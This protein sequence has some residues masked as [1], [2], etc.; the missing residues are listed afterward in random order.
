MSII[1]F[2]NTRQMEGI[3][4][5][6][7]QVKELIESK[8]NLSRTVDREKRASLTTNKV[9]RICFIVGLSLTTERK[10]EDYKD[11]QLSTTSARI[12]PSFFTMHDL[13]TLYSA[14]LKLRYAS[15]NIDWSQNAVLSRII[16]AEML[17]GR[18]Y[19]LADNNLDSIL[20]AVNNKV[21]MVKDIP[22]LNLII[23]NYGDV[24]MEATLD[25]NSR[26]IT[27]SQI[28]IAGATGSGKTNLLAVLMQQFRALSS[29]S[30]YPV[31]FLLFD[32]K[33]EFS[34]IQ[35]NH[36]LTHFDVDRSCILDPIE[37]PLP[38]TP[39]KDFTDRPINEIN[40]YSSEMAS[41]LC[42][43]D[44]VSASA[45]MNNRLSEAIVEAYKKTEGA[46]ITFNMMLEEY[47][48]KMTDAGKDDS[49]SSVLKQLVR[50]NIF[51]EKD[52]ADLVGDCYIIKMDGYPKDGPIAKAIVYFIIS[53]LNNIYEQ[54]E[55]QATNDDVV[56]IRH[57]SIIDEAHYMLDFDNRPLRN[58]IAVGRNKGLSI[59][60]ATQNMSSFKSKGFD[61]Y[62]N[63]QYP[64]IMKQQTIDDKVIKDLYGV[65]GQELQ[66]VRT[67]I[68][69]LQKGE[70]II[71]DQMAFALGMGKK[72]KK[73]NVTHLI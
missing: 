36:W 68:A 69:G 56:Q 4:N 58:L 25:I 60:L 32:Y 71:K 9:M 17:R 65:S 52:K 54:L 7:S 12:V 48:A 67:A 72:Y 62:A 44:R 57:F 50:A 18:N 43:I 59:I 70:L 10:E 38:F 30:Q 29:E 6:I 55:K 35:N 23:G 53:K 40:L 27:N 13:S 8:I 39:F 51:E 42:S 46:P 49:I 11:I 22:A 1:N 73:I 41:A 34:D 45:N 19:L 37:H 14:L 31:N 64:L 63:A 5:E 3:L 20:Y 47:Q 28:I 66:E 24:E 16:A 61:F 33:G 15:L 26:D 2:S 21:A